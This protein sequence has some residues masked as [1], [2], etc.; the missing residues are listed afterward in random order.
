MEVKYQDL[1]TTSVLTFNAE[2]RSREG[3]G[4]DGDGDLEEN[5]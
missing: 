2:M 4:R 3:H 1:V 5:E